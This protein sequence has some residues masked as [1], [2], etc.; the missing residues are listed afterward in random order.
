MKRDVKDLEKTAVKFWP[1]EI[2][3]TEKNASILPLLIESQESFISLL[4]IADKSPFACKTVLEGSDGIYSNLLLKHLMVL[5]DLG[6]EKLQRIK[7]ELP[8][9]FKK[10]EMVFVWKAKNHKYKFASYLNKSNWSNTSLK[11]DGPGLLVQQEITSEIEDVINLILFAGLSNS[12]NLP[13]YITELCTI[14]NLIGR[15][16]ELDAFVRQRYIFVSRITGGA[17]SN[18]LGQIAQKYIAQFLAEKLPS[19]NFEKSTIPN[20]TQNDRTSLSFDIVAESPMKQYVAIEVSFQ[21]TTNS[22][23]ERKAGQ[24]KDRQNNLHLA[25]HKIAY[26]IDG[27]GN[28]ER[29][30]AISSII[31]FSDITVN[32]SNNELLKLVSFL[33]KIK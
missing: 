14:G 32:F 27:A 23:I 22:V 29:T 9:I 1:K 33:K 19:W 17:T 7:K 21:V 6:G 2:A 3:E 31:E 11:V 13:N 10:G 4:N 16:R 30:S 25:G 24:A 12:P 8:K 15:K 28:F 20:I 26:I 5:A 18:S